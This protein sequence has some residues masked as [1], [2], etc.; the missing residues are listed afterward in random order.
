MGLG[1]IGPG[2]V[3]SAGV[4]PGFGPGGVGPGGLGYGPGG[5]GV[6]KEPKFMYCNIDAIYLLMGRKW[7]SALLGASVC[8][9]GK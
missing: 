8:F 9:A 3:G 2:G 6:G 4:G 1:V 5:V 7:H